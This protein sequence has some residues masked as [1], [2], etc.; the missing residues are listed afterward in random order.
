MAR[1]KPA[2]LGP[3]NP[4][5]CLFCRR[6]DG[7]FRRREHVWAESLGGTDILEPGIV[8]DRCNHGPLSRAD[9][10]LANYHAVA[11][12]RV[13]LGIPTKRGEPA[14]AKFANSTLVRPSRD[15]LVVI[16]PTEKDQ[17][18]REVAP[19]LQ[20]GNLKSGGIPGSRTSTRILHA[21]HKVAIETMY[22][23]EGPAA[24]FDPLLDRARKAIVLGRVPKGWLLIAKVHQFRPGLEIGW[25]PPKDASRYTLPG[26]TASVLGVR[27][28]ADLVRLGPDE[29]PLDEVG[30]A[31][32]VLRWGDL[33]RRPK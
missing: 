5:G 27:M 4:E 21:L 2:L 29:V 14:V 25:K 1:R 32:N 16:A 22:L 6:R 20:H 28:W 3:L 15:S 18:F 10:A 7:G 11:A 13:F 26:L 33:S 17:P 12:A 23:K 19:N 30:D 31:V 9:Q 24:A 8:C